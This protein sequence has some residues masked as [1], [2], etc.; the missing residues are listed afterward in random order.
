MPMVAE[1]TVRDAS[2][3]CVQYA[4]RHSFAEI[5]R[6]YVVRVLKE[7]PTDP[8]G[9]LIDEITKRPYVPVSSA[10]SNPFFRSA[11]ADAPA[12]RVALAASVERFFR[13]AASACASRV[14]GAAAGAPTVVAHGAAS[15]AALALCEGGVRLLAPG[16]RDDAE[17]VAAGDVEGTRVLLRRSDAHTYVD[18]YDADG[19]TPTY[20]A[21]ALG[22]TAVVELLADEGGADIARA[23]R[24][25][26]TALL[27]REWQDVPPPP[28]R[29]GQEDGGA[30]PLY[31][32]ARN[33]WANTARALIERGVDVN[34][35]KANGT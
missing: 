35:T 26:A 10:E 2:E 27:V 24:A 29:L 32:A 30:S 13:G 12:V 14:A 9:F 1:T 28:A 21:A 7:R 8:V 16:E 18:A 34:Q 11:A 6:E 23:T 17:L 22:H 15:A 4:E 33:G 31:I 20:V 3:D 19:A 25:D 5:L